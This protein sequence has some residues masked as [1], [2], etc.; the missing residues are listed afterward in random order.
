M[1]KVVVKQGESFESAFRKFKKNV[2]T[3]GLMKDLKARESYEKPTTKKKRKK[4]EAVKRLKKQIQNQK[5]PEKL[6]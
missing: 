6:Y 2:E 4:A 3:S 5:L 1:T